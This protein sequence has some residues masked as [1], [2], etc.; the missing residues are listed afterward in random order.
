MK[1]ND[2]TTQKRL[3]EGIYAASL[4]PIHPDLSCNTQELAAHCQ[5]I[6][7]RGCKGVV[8]FGTTGEGPSFSVEERLNALKEVIDLGVPPKH[9]ILAN[10]GANIPETVDLAKGALS[11]NCPFFLVT[12]PSFFKNVPENGVISFYQEVIKHV[13]NPNLRI[14]LY[15]IPQFSGVPLT[16]HIVEA[17]RKEFP[18]SV[19]GLKESEGNL[20]FTRALLQ[21]F[22][23]FQLFV[24]HENHILEAIHKGAAGSIGGIAN[25]YPELLCSLFEQGK[26]SANQNPQKLDAIIHAING[27]P[28]ISAFKAAME[29]KRGP[30][31]HHMRPPL[32]P[33]NPFE[34]NSFLNHF[35]RI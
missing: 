32:L 1:T 10:G 5:D 35:L 3:V 34:K 2:I 29:T 30:S 20:S 25:L 14:L 27:Y 19:I 9:I 22:P 13:G 17:L 31:W 23:D 15:H 33:L 11:L 26:H 28:F 7:Q 12:P 18:E 24:G 4:T 16:L 21:R 6:I 8:L